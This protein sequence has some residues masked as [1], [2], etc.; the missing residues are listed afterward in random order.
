MANENFTSSYNIVDA[1]PSEGQDYNAT[2]WSVTDPMD[3]ANWTATMTSKQ[4]PL[5]DCGPSEYIFIFYAYYYGLMMLVTMIGVV[6]NTAVIRLFI[7][8]TCMFLCLRHR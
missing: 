6:G 1:W 3:R 7:V 8:F 4:E 5:L 2:L